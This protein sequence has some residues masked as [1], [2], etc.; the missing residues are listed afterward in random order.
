MFGEDQIGRRDPDAVASIIE[1]ADILPYRQRVSRQTA[2]AL[3]LSSVT[4]SSP[5]VCL[6]LL[7]AG[8]NGAATFAQ[9][10]RPQRADHET[11]ASFYRQDGFD[12][13]ISNV[14]DG[15]QWRG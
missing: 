4:S 12:A 2:C 5:A 15:H 7:T 10:A 3:Q 9:I 8:R 6:Q 13:W 14:W 1:Q 11:N